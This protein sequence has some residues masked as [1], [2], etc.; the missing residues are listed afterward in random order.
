MSKK[1]FT[2]DLAD[3]IQPTVVKSR[4]AAP[5]IPREVEITNQRKFS[6][7]QSRMRRG[8]TPTNSRGI[9]LSKARADERA[10]RVESRKSRVIPSVKNI[11]YPLLDLLTPLSSA[12]IPK[13]L[14][15]IIVLLQLNR[16]LIFTSPFFVGDL[17]LIDEEQA[18]EM[19]STTGQFSRLDDFQYRYHHKLANIK[20]YEGGKYQFDKRKLPIQ[21]SDALTALLKNS[22]LPVS[23]LLNLTPVDIMLCPMKGLENKRKILLI[24]YELFD[25]LRS[26]REGEARNLP[27][28]IN[29]KE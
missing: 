13:G 17:L 29:L 20:E 4:E 19:L 14:A 18:A 7:I 12:D 21:L 8:L 1:S 16:S 9:A 24:Q 3:L 26:L 25:V 27:V 5:E 15:E 28:Y 6:K 2:P 10:G 22:E 23:S 11:P